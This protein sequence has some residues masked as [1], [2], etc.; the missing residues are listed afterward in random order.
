MGFEY[1]DE[2]IVTP[3]GIQPVVVMDWV[4]AKPL[5]AYIEENLYDADKLKEL[6]ASFAQMTNDL[7][8]HGVSHGDLQHGNILVK[9]NG[10]IVLVD[11][12]SMYV[13]ELAGWT[14]VISGLQ[15][16]Q[17]PARWENTY[18][19]RKAD[20]F[21]EMI[22]YTSIVALAELPQLWKDL[23]M[24]DSETLL[25]NENDIKKR[26]QSPIFEV[27]ESLEG[28]ADLIEQIKEAL[29][30]TSIDEI[31]PLETNRTPVADELRKLWNDNGYKPIPSYERKDVVLIANKW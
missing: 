28:C 23:K 3:L 18:L 29:Q 4:D 14:D 15:G 21:S 8:K 17:H 1:V 26:G 9:P 10:N 5:K 24:S 13:P 20:F 12:D 2:G 6:A 31:E 7:H 19:S 25:F 11:Y 22:I 27:V 30:C 16:Y